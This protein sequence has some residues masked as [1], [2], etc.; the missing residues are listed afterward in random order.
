MLNIL[1]VGPECFLDV[2]RKD[3]Q[4]TLWKLSNCSQNMTKVW[5]QF[6][7]DLHGGR[8][9]YINIVGPDN[10]HNKQPSLMMDTHELYVECNQCL[11]CGY[12]LNKCR[13]HDK[14]IHNGYIK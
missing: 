4:D 11:S 5:C 1:D 10:D 14:Q 2:P 8:M 9:L 13:K 7:L 6:P 3:M 12:I